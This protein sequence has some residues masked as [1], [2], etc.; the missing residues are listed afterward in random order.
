MYVYEGILA[1]VHNRCQ[2]LHLPVPCHAQQLL[3]FLPAVYATPQFTT[4]PNF[5]PWA[6]L[7]SYLD[8]KT[9]DVGAITLNEDAAGV[10]KSNLGLWFLH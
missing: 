3:H 1:C 2:G 7:L 10:P 6:Y 9:F 5:K 4:R 8:H